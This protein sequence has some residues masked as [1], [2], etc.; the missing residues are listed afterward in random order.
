MFAYCGNDPVNCIDI[1]GKL[2]YAISISLCAV[3]GGGDMISYSIAR[4][5]NGNIAIQKAS[6]NINKKTE[7]GVV[8][9]CSASVSFTE[10]WVWVDTVDDMEDIVANVGGT[11]EFLPF[12]SGGGDVLIA[13]VDNPQICG[14]SKTGSLSVGIDYFHIGMAETETIFKINIFECCDKVKTFI[15]DTANEAKNKLNSL[16]DW[17]FGD[18]SKQE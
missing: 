16:L 14:I 9:M 13:S 11:I 7:G 6:T 12:V 3:C 2:V 18:Y 17:A 1:S 8:G 4:D 15:E 5:D 10:A